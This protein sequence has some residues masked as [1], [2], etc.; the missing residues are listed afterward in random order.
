MS[1]TKADFHTF[2]NYC[3][4]FNHTAGLIRE[5][6]VRSFDPVL[7]DLIDANNKAVAKAIEY[8]KTKLEK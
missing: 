6:E 3:A 5:A 4:G 2:V 7:A 1:M 8:C